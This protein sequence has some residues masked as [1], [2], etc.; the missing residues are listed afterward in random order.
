MIGRADELAARLVTKTEKVIDDGVEKTWV[1]AHADSDLLADID[2][3]E[4]KALYL[5]AAPKVIRDNKRQNALK[6]PRRPDIDDWLESQLKADPAAKS[7]YLWD[8]APEWLTDQIGIDRFKKRVTA[9][10]K[11]VAK[12]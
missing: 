3:A 12:T 2:R 8:I 11:R 7:P 9:A 10:R 1:L 5:D 6:Q 4:S